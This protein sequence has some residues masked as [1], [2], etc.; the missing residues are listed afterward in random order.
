MSQG[1]AKGG[2][3]SEPWGSPD[4][5]TS[6]TLVAALAVA[7][8]AV[9]LQFSE[10][11]YFS[12]LLDPPDAGNA[13]NYDVQPVPGTTGLNGA[14]ARPVS[15]VSVA[16]SPMPGSPTGTFLLVTLDR[17]MTPFP[18][19]YEVTVSGLYSADLN[20]QLAEV[21]LAF[22]AVFKQVVT[23]KITSATPARDFSNPQSLSGAL[24]PLPDPNNPL[25]LGSMPVDDSGDYAFDEGLA[26]Y[27]KRIY[28]RV[29]TTPGGFVHLGQGYGVGIR[30]Y[31]KKLGTPAR[32]NDLAAAVEQQVSL[33]PETDKVTCT[34]LNS[35]KPGFF[36]L[37]IAVKL[38][39]GSFVKFYGEYPAT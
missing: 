15:V 28:R 1:W 3:G 22:P 34:V 17:P 27:K 6:L 33:E 14:A 10:P 23:P 21:T 32:R 30:A 25:V 38:R 2:W 4:G 18:A 35:S 11:V 8:N 5:A 37:A 29:M 9:Q 26:G 39:S 13:D 19:Q 12:G 7:E 36:G 31:G 20:D 16:V 24:D